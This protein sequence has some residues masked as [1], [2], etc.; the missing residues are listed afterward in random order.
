MWIYWILMFGLVIIDQVIKAAIVSHLTL[1]AT[2][3]VVPGLL[4]LTNLH[5]N[6]AAWSILEGKMWFF[7]LISIVALGVMVYLLW[8]LRQRRLYE[9][10]IIFMIAGTLGNFIDRVR[11]G[12]VVDMFQL[13]FINFP[14]FNFA[15]T[16]LTVGVILV[17]IAVLRDDSFDK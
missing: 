11:I 7:Y 8:R 12:Y 13:D 1:G 10:G 9:F 5:N 15:D 3:T 2:Q 16:C 6:G 17:L 14:I 4:S